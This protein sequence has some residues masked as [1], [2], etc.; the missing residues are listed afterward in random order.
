MACGYVPRWRRGVGV[1]AADKHGSSECRCDC[2]DCKRGQHALDVH[3]DIYVRGDG[4]ISPRGQPIQGR[5]TRYGGGGAA[6]EG[7][8]TSAGRRRRREDTHKRAGRRACEAN[9]WK[10]GSKKWHNHTPTCLDGKFKISTEVDVARRTSLFPPSP[11]AE[12]N[13][14][15]QTLFAVYSFLDPIFAVAVGSL[16]Y[17]SYE[18]KVGRPAGHSLNEL[19]SKRWERLSAARKN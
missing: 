19:V 7:R 3:G 6:T 16:S 4:G 2:T 13:R 10:E 15:T 17:Y 11:L 1:G 9:R 12:T 8:R 14:D 5:V 18:R